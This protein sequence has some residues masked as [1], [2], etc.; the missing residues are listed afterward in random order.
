M[1]DP[2]WSFSHAHN[3]LYRKTSFGQS[4]ENFS[5]Q[6]FQQSEIYKKVLGKFCLMAEIFPSERF[7]NKVAF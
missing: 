7:P 5:R 3:T 4:D 1:E 2:L 6:N